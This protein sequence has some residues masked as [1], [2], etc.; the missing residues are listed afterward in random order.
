M[1]VLIS[2]RMHATCAMLLKECIDGFP[3][4]LRII[5]VAVNCDYCYFF[6]SHQNVSVAFWVSLQTRIVILYQS[7][8]KLRKRF[9]LSGRFL[10]Q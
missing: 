6:N 4:F 9:F 3:K 2:I 7:Y 5:S 10:L 8:E 1:H